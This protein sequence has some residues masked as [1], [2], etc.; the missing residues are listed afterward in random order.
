M[1]GESKWGS[2]WEFGG[3]SRGPQKSWR[4]KARWGK[5]HDRAAREAGDY[6]FLMICLF[7]DLQGI[8]QNSGQAQGRQTDL[9]SWGFSQG[10]KFRILARDLVMIME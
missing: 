1:S 3:E 10:K 8:S 9:L 7:C 6:S 2:R 5:K 4:G